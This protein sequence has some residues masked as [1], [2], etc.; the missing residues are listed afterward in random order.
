MSSI[1]YMYVR[2]DQY[3]PCGCVAIQVHRSKNRVEYGLSVRHPIDCKNAAGKQLKFNRRQAQ[4]L[5]LDR[6]I[7]APRYA[8]IDREA[9]QHDISRAV[10]QDIVANGKSPTRAVRFAKNWLKVADL[11]ADIIE[12]IPM[13]RLEGRMYARRGTN[14]L[15]AVLQPND[16]GD[17]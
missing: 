12:P 11:M 14:T 15:R 8:Y 4:S 17:N 1:R 7:E 16:L 13:D 3:G 2:D 9:T 10:M 6:M 5:A